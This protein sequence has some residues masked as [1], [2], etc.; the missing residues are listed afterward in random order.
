ML[1]GMMLGDGTLKQE[2]RYPSFLIEQRDE[3][4]VKHLWDWFKEFN[5]VNNLYTKRLKV[6]KRL[7]K[8]GIPYKDSVTYRFSTC[9]FPYF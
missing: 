1:D 7:N 4:F 6:D 8:D 3:E 5:L 2:C 9:S